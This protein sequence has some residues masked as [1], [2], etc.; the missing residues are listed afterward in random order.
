MKTTPNTDSEVYLHSL[1]EAVTRKL[2]QFFIR[3]VQLNPQFEVSLTQTDKRQIENK[4]SRHE[5]T[6]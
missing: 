4:T 5:K 1:S 3:F 2:K 6:N